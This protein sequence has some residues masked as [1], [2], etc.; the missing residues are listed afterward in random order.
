[1]L[2]HLANLQAPSAVRQGIPIDLCEL[3]AA[4]S[5]LRYAC[6]SP[7]GYITRPGQRL[8]RPRASANSGDAPKPTTGWPA[9][10]LRPLM[11]RVLFLLG[12][13][14]VSL[15]FPHPLCA[16]LVRENST[17]PAPQVTPQDKSAATQLPTGK[18]RLS[19]EMQITGDE[20]WL[21]TG[22][23]IQAG[24]H[25]LITATGKLRY[26]D[27]ADDNGPDGLARG[28]TP[29]RDAARR[30]RQGKGLPRGRRLA[31][32]RSRPRPGVVR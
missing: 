15:A 8:R 7:W 16:Q 20:S 14:L 19:Q 30:A 21:D 26:A 4:S 24:E 10:M 9:P 32:S 13:S 2:R 6:S 12:S 1:M 23:D 27:A 31:A 25:V 11:Q 22:I 28:S 29:V 5:C 17:P 18:K 3:F